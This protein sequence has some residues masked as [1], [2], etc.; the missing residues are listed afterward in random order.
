MAHTSTWRRS[1]HSDMIVFWAR[2]VPCFGYRVFSAQKL[3]PR[4]TVS[5]PEAQIR[6]V[7]KHLSRQSVCYST[8]RVSVQ[9]WTLQNMNKT[10]KSF[11]VISISCL[12]MSYVKNYTSG[13]KYA[14]SFYYCFLKTQL[15]RYFCE[16][17]VCLTC[18]EWLLYTVVQLSFVSTTA[19]ASPCMFMH[20]SR[21][22]F[23]DQL[24]QSSAVVKWKFWVIL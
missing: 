3:A 16:I 2:G 13:C 1:Q 22:Y 5:I 9:L 17:V 10:F 23:N 14:S 6:E 8:S 7:I 24:C 12:A 11:Y 15:K 18:D 20:P 4:R 21:A 19:H